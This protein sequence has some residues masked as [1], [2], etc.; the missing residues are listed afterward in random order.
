MQSLGVD[1]IGVNCSTGPMEMVPLVKTMAEY[2]TV[3]LIAK[4]NAGLPKQK[5]G[6]TYYD[7]EP[8]EFARIMQEVVLAAPD[9][10]KA[11]NLSGLGWSAVGFALLSM[12]IYIC[13]LLCSHI[14]AFHVQ[15]NMRS[16]L[17]RHILTLPM[18]FMDSEG[19]VRI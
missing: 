11:Q 4:P 19:S 18:G 16:T 6:E 5:N 12:I 7:V 15:A 14:A 17:M 8:D 9:Y 13:A 1:A 2:S 10:S 3:P